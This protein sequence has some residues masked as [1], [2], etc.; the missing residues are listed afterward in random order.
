MIHTNS[1]VVATDT[2]VFHRHSGDHN[3]K[4]SWCLQ[5][6]SWRTQCFFTWLLGCRKSRLS[7]TAIQ[8]NSLISACGD[9]LF[10]HP[11]LIL[12][13]VFSNISKSTDTCTPVGVFLVSLLTGSMK[14]I[15]KK[16]L[17]LHQLLTE[18]WV[19]PTLGPDLV[20]CTWVCSAQTYILVHDP[21]VHYWWRW[22]WWWW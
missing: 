8:C 17:Y 5:M 4:V 18:Q 11:F 3:V 21:D 22:W 16:L 12:T 1:Y 15:Y 6:D 19:L 14:Y 10:S 13:F 9:A 2:L 20:L 7:S